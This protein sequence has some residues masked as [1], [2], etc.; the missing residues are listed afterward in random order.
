MRV[1]ITAKRAGTVADLDQRKDLTLM[2]SSQDVEA[3]KE[4]FGNRPAV[5]R[6]DGFLVK[7]E[8]GDYTEVYG[9]PGNIAYV[10]KPVFKIERRVMSGSSKKGSPRNP[11]LTR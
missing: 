9:Y 2:D 7:L 4:H 3:I 5:M 1:K 11:R 8:D 6:F 10:S